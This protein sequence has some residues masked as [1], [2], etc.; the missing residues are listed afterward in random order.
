MNVLILTN[1]LSVY[2]GSEIQVFELYCYLKNNNHS[3]Q[4]YA[5]YFNQP[6]L[7]LFSAHDIIND[8]DKIDLNQYDA[9]WSQHCIFARLFKNKTYDNLNIKL[10]SVHL[11]PFEPFEYSSLTYMKPINA[12]F[13]ANSLETKDKLMS[14]GIDD[15]IHV[16]NNFCPSAY[17]SNEKPQTL[18]KILIVSNH[19]PKEITEASHLLKKQGYVVKHIGLGN[20]NKQEL[21]TPK[22]INEFDCIISIG[23]TVQYAILNNRAIYCYD[24][25]GGAGYLN[26]DN[27]EIAKYHNFSGRGFD[28]HKTPEQIA[29]EIIN[30]FQENVN[31]VSK[32]TDKDSYV[33][34][35]NIEQILSLPKIT[36][37]K[38][39][40][41][42]IRL[43]YP[44]EELIARYYNHCQNL[45]KRLEKN[46]K[47]K[48]TFIKIIYSLLILILILSYLI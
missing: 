14:L 42:E 3:V 7:G 9:V 32:I 34:E 13:I 10:F 26:D 28:E 47:R 5:N 8:I 21:I 29:N 23:K 6:M 16:S 18:N 31:F 17:I 46:I 4:I 2:S 27:Y 36:I 35:N 19:A 45:D 1:H 30:Q 15:P 41:N 39:Q 12:H 37:S 44:I 25:F 20:E 24:H 22:I 40:Q 43:S 33:L 38:E 48:K 11:S